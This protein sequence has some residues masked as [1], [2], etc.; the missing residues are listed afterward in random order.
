MLK[1]KKTRLMTILATG[2]ASL[3]VAAPASAAPAVQDGLV[4]VN[5]SDVL[6]QVPISLAANLCDVNVAVL[7]QVT[8]T[9]NGV[10]TATA[11]S[12]ASAGPSQG[13]G[14]GATQNGL[15][16]VNLSDIT[17]QVPVSVAANICDVNVAVL[18]NVTDAGGPTCDATAESL[19]S[20]GRGNRGGRA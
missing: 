15:V 17:I 4:N 3:A 10:C 11:E 16:N 8:D 14:G 9:G 5:V 12:L 1:S 7:A 19:A 13:G 2:A 18:A 6:V 20:P